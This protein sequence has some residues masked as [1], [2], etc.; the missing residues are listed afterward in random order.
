VYQNP[1]VYQYQAPQGADIQIIPGIPDPN[2][3]K[4]YRLQVGAFSIQDAAAQAAR[5]I[6][7]AGFNAA[8]E[9]SGTVYRALAVNIPAASVYAAASR[10]GLAGFKQ[11]WVR[12]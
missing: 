10:L 9:Q 12:E 3:G 1:P 6:Q 5:Q 2:S 11:I 4:L 7:A 8:L